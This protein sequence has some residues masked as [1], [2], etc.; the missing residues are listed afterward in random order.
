MDLLKIKPKY[1]S[2]ILRGLKGLPPGYQN[3]ESNGCDSSFLG[4]MSSNPD[5]PKP[6]FWNYHS[7]G[8]SLLPS[9]VG[10]QLYRPG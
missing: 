10:K 1:V 7:L 8:N 9:E 5:I 6:N 4:T 2:P 3:P